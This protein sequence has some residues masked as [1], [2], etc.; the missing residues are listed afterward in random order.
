MLAPVRA[1]SSSWSVLQLYRAGATKQSGP[2]QP[3]A[4]PQA[5]TA[6]QNATDSRGVLAATQASAANQTQSTTLPANTPTSVG[7]QAAL[8][9]TAL[10]DPNNNKY[11]AAEMAIRGRMTVLEKQMELDGTKPA[12]EKDPAVEMKFFD[13]LFE[14]K[15][16][17][18]C[19]SRKYQ[20]GSDDMSVSFQT[21]QS[22]S[23]EVVASVVR[24][25]E[26][27]HVKNEQ[28]NAVRENREVVSQSVTLHNSICPD[29]GKTYV[30]GGTT[31][32]VTRANA[33]DPQV[34]NQ[35]PQSLAESFA[36]TA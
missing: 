32:T 13:E 26:M 14:D 8:A 36:A 24:G 19:E 2:A 9:P 30:S 16:C 25:H 7:E 3:V 5:V 31:E 15:S 6:V 23:P 18:T 20:D 33:E 12:Q 21:A 17:P 4:A 27:E 35:K 28:L 34:E 22:I 11:T 29:C 1:V 10:P